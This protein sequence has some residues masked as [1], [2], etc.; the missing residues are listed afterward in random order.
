MKSLALT[1][2]RLRVVTSTLRD[3]KSFYCKIKG[4][5]KEKRRERRQWRNKYTAL[6]TKLMGTCSRRR[7]T[8]GRVL[9]GTTG[10]PISLLITWRPSEEGIWLACSDRNSCH[11]YGMMK[12]FTLKE[13]S[14]VKI[15]MR[16]KTWHWCSHKSCWG[17]ILVCSRGARMILRNLS[18]YSDTSLPCWFP[19]EN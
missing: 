18:D 10:S 6:W 1:S 9:E 16:G 15:S 14:W 17:M 13:A 2:S 19:N 8:W 12:Q 5:V 11:S 4:S 7:M 3:S